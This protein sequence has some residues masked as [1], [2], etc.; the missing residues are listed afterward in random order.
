MHTLFCEFCQARQAPSFGENGDQS[1]PIIYPWSHTVG[2]GKPGRPKDH[3]CNICAR[4]RGVTEHVL[5]R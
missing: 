1:G 4:R 2:K 5:S 3:I